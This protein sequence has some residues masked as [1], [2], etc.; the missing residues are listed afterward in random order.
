[1]IENDSKCFFG[2]AQCYHNFLRP[3]TKALIADLA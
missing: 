3:A 2:L 1:V